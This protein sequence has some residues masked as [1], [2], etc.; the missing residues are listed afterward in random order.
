[1]ARYEEYGGRKGSVGRILA[2]SR[3]FGEATA[4]AVL[5]CALMLLLRRG[6]DLRLVCIH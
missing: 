4:S 3:Q 5:C 6:R 1:M 2:S